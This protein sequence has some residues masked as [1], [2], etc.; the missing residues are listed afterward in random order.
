MAL[1]QEIWVKDIQSNLYN[2]LEFINYGTDHSEYIAYSTVH[3]PQAGSAPEV[4]KSRTTLP[5]PISQRTDTELT[6][7]VV[8]FTT[9]PI[10]V[11]DLEAFQLSY[12]KRMS[13]MGE[14]SEKLRERIGRETAF[15]WAVS[16]DANRIVRTSGANGTTLAPGAT[17]TRK[18][19]VKEDIGKLKTI[20][21]R[22]LVPM[23]ERYLLLDYGMYV[24][25]LESDA[26]LRQD[27][28]GKANLPMGAVNLILGFNI[29][30]Y[31]YPV[32]YDN[33]ATPAKKS[34][35][36]DNTGYPVQATTDNIGCI[37]FSRYAVSKA[38]GGINVFMENR[39]P[40]YYGDIISAL[41]H[42]GSSIRRTD[43]KGVCVIVQST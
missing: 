42:H 8:P 20:L 31:N 24:E 1:L 35:L 27:F 34:P 17:G 10:V 36:S 11:S 22:D 37:A 9:N 25:L 19:L 33:A 5:A 2:G 4:V 28:M 41:V 43:K 39:V 21:D 30:T 16:A 23:S 38:L 32:I 7:P 29:L 18:K 12:D 3:L 14:H 13:V 26:I 40:E 6:Y 15:N